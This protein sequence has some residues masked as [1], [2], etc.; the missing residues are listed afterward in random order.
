MWYEYGTQGSYLSAVNTSDN[1]FTVAR[2]GGI[3]ACRTQ[4]SKPESTILIKD[5][6]NS[7][8]LFIIAP[9]IDESARNTEVKTTNISRE[10]NQNVNL[11]C[12]F[13]RGSL[14]FVLYWIA[15][16]P[17]AKNQCLSSV[18]LNSH[19]FAFTYNEHCCSTDT[20]QK[21]IYNWNLSL[22]N[23]ATQTHYLGIK[24][25]TPSDNGRYLCVIRTQKSGKITWE[26]ASNLSLQVNDT[27]DT[28]HTA[29]HTI[30][31]S[32][33]AY[34]AVGGLVIV[35][36]IILLVVCCIKSKGKKTETLHRYPQAVDTA[37]ND[38]CIPYAVSERPDLQQS[39]D[40]L[41]SK[42][43]EIRDA[44]YSE[45]QFKAAESDL[46]V[47]YSVVDIKRH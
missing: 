3:L 19:T 33:I 1:Q 37:E 41:Y 29:G 39:P 20:I 6:C 15:I 8:N 4:N 32:Y 43:C 14:P 30:H 46:C 45:V 23:D 36:G 28:T 40:T 31:C 16:Y 2:G 11:S 35:G 26:I 18:E 44:E 38:E 17:D 21:K 42:P 27:N 24:H 5:S 10:V 34:G 22:I 9:E 12:Q 25:I 47:A 7:H 13:N